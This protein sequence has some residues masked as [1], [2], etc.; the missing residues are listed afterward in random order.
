MSKFISVTFISMMVI[1]LSACSSIPA[2]KPAAI[3]AT[4]LLSPTQSTPLLQ[5]SAGNQISSLS[6]VSPGEDVSIETLENMIYE[7]QAISEVLPEN[8]GQVKLKD[9]Y[10]EAAQPNS[11]SNIKV[12]L[13]KNAIGDLNRDSL[14]DGFSILSV[15]T[16][17]SGTFIYLIAITNQQG[18]PVQ[19]A[20]YF[21]GDRVKINSLRIENEVL[22]VDMQTHKET[23]PACCPSESI[24]KKFVIEDEKFV[25][26][27]EQN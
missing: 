4:T 6:S 11:A 24:T 1:L 12:K 7:I 26:I 16:G 20:E 10:F 9:G 19:A 17:G 21:L 5:G 27:I 25:E 14:E 13:I 2:D 23:D 3:S 22:H 18:Q 15:E 8:G